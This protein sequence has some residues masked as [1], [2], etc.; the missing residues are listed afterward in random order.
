MK[1]YVALL[2]CLAMVLCLFG[3]KTQKCEIDLGGNLGKVTL[4]GKAF[5]SSYKV[6]DTPEDFFYEDNVEIIV[7]QD[8]SCDSP[9]IAVYRMKKGS[10]TL[11]S[12]VKKEAD[13]FTNGYYQTFGAESDMPAG[14]Y[15]CSW[16]I[17]NDEVYYVDS[18]YYEDGEYIVCLDV[19]AK[20]EEIKIGDSNV[21]AYV[22]V[23][24]TSYMDDDYKNH[25]TIFCGT[26]TEDYY[27]S[28]TWIGKW[29]STYEYLEW[30]WGDYYPDGLPITK[31]QYAENL[32]KYDKGE[33]TMEEYYSSL[34]SKMEYDSYSDE[35]CKFDYEA[36]FYVLGGTYGGTEA[37]FKVNNDWYIAWFQSELNPKPAFASTFLDL[38]HTK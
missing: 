37:W 23:G 14:F 33:Y 5:G 26:Y 29:E 24:Y 34:G 1:K 2:L 11:E 35:K 27:F 25:G 9:Y 28:N 19:Y 16:N 17:V 22:P 36:G 4:E 38:L 7:Y 10:D 31:E 18:E 13:A 30:L 21:Y 32:A 3:C 20:T 6:I 12:F 8:M 15:L